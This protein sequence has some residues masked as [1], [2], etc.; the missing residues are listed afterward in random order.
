MQDTLA[1]YLTNVSGGILQRALRNAIGPAIDRLS[2]QATS[3]AGLVI[4]AGGGTLVKTGGSATN[5][6]VDGA[7]RVI[8][9]ATDMPA[10][11]GNINAGKYNVYVFYLDRAGTTT[12]AR[13]IEGATAADVV[14][15]PTPEKK[16][17]IGYILVTYASEFVGGTTPLD[18]AT[19]TY[20][21]P[22]GAFDPSALLGG[23]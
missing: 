11:V 1:R 6:V 19:T 10:L 9:S 5:F 3:A 13:G 23:S 12:V 7:H 20:H 2:S 14:F 15:P 21:S 18:T 8:G 22:I 17:I 4:K 16:A